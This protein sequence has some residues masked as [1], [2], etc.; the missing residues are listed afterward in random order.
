MQCKAG[1]LD[2]L[3]SQ[4]AAGGHR[5]AGS[6]GARNQREDLRQTD[7]EAGSEGHVLAAPEGE[8]AAVGDIEHDAEDDGR[9]GDDGDVAR[10]EE[11][12]YEIQSLMRVSLSVCC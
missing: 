10:S 2:P 8:G 6:A 11:H 5:D 3:E 4:E 9:P 1:R 12:T 7:D